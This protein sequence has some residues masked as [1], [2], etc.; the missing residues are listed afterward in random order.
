MNLKKNI[1]NDFNKTLWS[2]NL[3]IINKT[4]LWMAWIFL[5]SFILSNIN[6]WISWTIWILFS[7][8]SLVLILIL[9]FWYNKLSYQAMSWLT[10][11]FAVFQWIWLNSV[12][13]QYTWMEITQAFL[14]TFILFIIM[15]WYWF[16][17]KKD[18]SWWWTIL[19]IWLIS[20]IIWSLLNIFI[21]QSTM[22]ELFISWFAVIIFLWFTAY[23]LQMLK[24][25]SKSW[26][27]KVSVLFWISLYLNFINI[28][29]SLLNIFSSDD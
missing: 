21:F 18:L 11:L 27:D 12:F 26:D 15:S 25:M 19:L 1:I 7:I 22:I 2:V 5:T 10:I 16:L 29:L 6:L 13:Q 20:I 28:M 24:T 17:T 4:F 9:S 3:E 8:L 23:D 14:S